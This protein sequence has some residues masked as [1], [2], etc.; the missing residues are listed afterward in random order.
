MVQM[1][2]TVQ[3]LSTSD[4][5]ALDMVE[6]FLHVQEL[7]FRLGNTKMP[8]PSGEPNHA[9]W[10]KQDESQQLARL[11]ALFIQVERSHIHQLDSPNPTPWQRNSLFYQQQNNIEWNLLQEPDVF[12]PSRATLRQWIED[13][14]VEHMHI[15]ILWHCSTLL[16]NRPFLPI[17][18]SPTQSAIAKE[19][20]QTASSS[21]VPKDFSR[22]RVKRCIRSAAAIPSICSEVVGGGSYL[23]VCRYVRESPVY[24]LT[25]CRQH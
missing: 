16:H 9:A 12:R 8:L 22:E 2:K 23:P 1:T 15:V 4:V 6:V 25:E 5:D 19:H 20:Q 10:A 7:T 11:L 18:N 13:G 17:P 3:E 21:T 14:W 24:K